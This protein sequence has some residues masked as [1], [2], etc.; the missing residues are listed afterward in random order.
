MTLFNFNACELYVHTKAYNGILE[1]GLKQMYVPQSV[2]H[3]LLPQI[4]D[5]VTII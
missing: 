3:I 5:Q 4:A 1:S 2:V